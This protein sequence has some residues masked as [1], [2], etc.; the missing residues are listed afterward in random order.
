[1][2]VIG[3]LSF[4]S[5]RDED[6]KFE[7]I[8]FKTT[9][10]NL[11]LRNG[12]SYYGGIEYTGGEITFSATGKNAGNRFL[13]EIKVGDWFHEYRLSLISCGC[14]GRFPV[15]PRKKTVLHEPQAEQEN[16]NRENINYEKEK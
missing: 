3:C 14:F 4:T 13:P 10:V 6:E 8:E 11:S 16:I 15:F 1:M 12:I 9:G 7:N 2:S 5:C